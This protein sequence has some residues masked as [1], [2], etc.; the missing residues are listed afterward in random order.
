MPASDVQILANR[1]NTELST[2]PKTDDG[3]AQAPAN[4]LKHGMI[5]SGVVLAEEDSAEVERLS[6]AFAGATPSHFDR[7]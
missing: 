5:G 2:G 3:K 4:S 6:D 1:K 7:R